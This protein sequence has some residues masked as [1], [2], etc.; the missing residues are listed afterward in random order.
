MGISLLPTPTGLKCMSKYVKRHHQTFVHPEN[1][2][3]NH[4]RLRRR[5]MSGF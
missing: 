4:D 5:R 3:V 1:T 2:C